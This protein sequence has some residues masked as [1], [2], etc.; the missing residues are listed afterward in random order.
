MIIPYSTDAPIYHLPIATGAMIAVNTVVYLATA[1]LDEY[2]IEEYV[3]PWIL[4]YGTFN[5]LQWVTSNFLHAGFFHLLGNMFGLWAFG[6]LV[7]GKV[8]WLRFLAIF[9][10]IGITQCAVEQTVMLMADG[11]GS[12]GASSIVFGLLAICLIW[13]P[14]NEM[15]C[16]IW[17][18][19]RV[20]VMDL[21]VMALAEINIGIEILVSV[22][23]GLTWGSQVLHL[24]G[25]AMGLGIGIV[26]LKMKWVDCEGW[27]LFSVWKGSNVKTIAERDAEAWEE[28][29]KE[30]KVEQQAAQMSFEQQLARGHH[31]VTRRLEEGDPSGAYMIHV[32]LS[33][34]V[35][36]WEI[37]QRELQTIIRDYHRRKMWSQ[38][39]PAMVEYLHRFH[40]REIPLRL[41]LAQ[42]LVLE[43]QRPAQA[44]QVLSKLNEALLDDESAQMVHKIRQKALALQ[45][46]GI[47]EPPPENW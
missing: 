45:K 14:R 30:K 19:W 11:G 18:L 5:P 42:I 39:V 15:S 17:I 27:D 21:S 3:V 24:M 16:V 44:I 23:Y 4:Q 38:S 10:G 47:P 1:Q 33:E 35:P 9:F 8:G 36:G 22:I 2:Q 43:Q 12:L 20:V 13:A 41:K 28:L 32:R 6:L 40:D 37:G 46:S 7:E 29:E 26:M 31:E 25:V 34:S